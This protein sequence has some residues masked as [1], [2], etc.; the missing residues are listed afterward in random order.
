MDNQTN[1]GGQNVQRIEHNPVNQQ[2]DIQVKPKVSLWMI[3]ILLFALLFLVTVGIF[4]VNYNK[5]KN[6]QSYLPSI[7]PEISPIP[8]RSLKLE[9]YINKELLGENDNYSVYLINPKGED[10]LERTGEIIVYEKKTKVVNKINGSFS[11]FGETMVADDGKGEYVLLSTGTYVERGAIV[12]S[13]IN[14][15][16][17]V[18]D[19]CVSGTHNPFFFWGNFIV[20]NNC[21]DRK[22]KPGSPSI[23]ALNL[24]NGQTKILFN[25]DPTHDYVINNI[26]G[27]TLYYDEWFYKMGTDWFNRE[28]LKTETK[29]YNLLSL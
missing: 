9:D 2:A 23:T 4:V 18:K 12:I 16:Q 25:V 19:F 28:H 8:T 24:I 1:I 22:P 21:V 5:I 14:K 17:A 3:S 15:N 26:D 13:L 7:T 29:T 11:I 10:T 20:Y 27:N 6:S